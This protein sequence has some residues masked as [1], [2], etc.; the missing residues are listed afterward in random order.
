MRNVFLLLA[1]TFCGSVFAQTKTITFK[2]D[3]AMGK[4]A[5]IYTYFGCI[6]SGK[7]IPI[8]EMNHGNDPQLNAAAWTFSALGCGKGTLRAL[9]KFEE[10]STIPQNVVIVSAELKLYGATHYLSG[11]TVGNSLYPG[12][13]YS[14]QGSNAAYIQRVT[15]DW[16]DQTVTWNTQPTTTAENRIAIPQTTSQWNWG[17][18]DS[19][20]NLIKM[21][22]DMVTNPET[23][24]GFMIRLETESYYRSVQFASSNHPDP[25]L[26]P[27]LTVTYEYVVSG[28]TDRYAE[29][30]NPQAKK[31]DGS[32]TYKRI[33]EPI[34]G[35]M[36]STALNY[37]PIATIAGDGV[38]VYEV[39]NQK[40]YGCTDPKALNYNPEATDYDYSREECRCVYANDENTFKPIVIPEVPVDTLGAR[41]VEDCWFTAANIIS[42]KITKLTVSDIDESEN[43]HGKNKPPHLHAYAEWEIVK[44]A[45]GKIDTIRERVQY[46]LDGKNSSMDNQPTLFYMSVVCKNPLYLKS[47]IEVVEA[48]G[49][50]FSAFAYFDSF[51]GICQ[52]LVVSKNN[53]AVYPNPFTDK[54]TVLVKGAKTADIA[55]YSIEGS[56]LATYRNLNEVEIATSK[57]PA[58]V[59]VVKV[60]ADGETESVR[61]VKK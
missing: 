7:T 38:C 17:F 32:C 8:D 34:T 30:Y 26:H 31:N 57:L 14:D 28:C 53:V 24:F 51:T 15:S 22:Q 18:T 47:G 3:S 11:I 27:E 42:A 58:G 56:L 49:Y 25:A 43:N 54:L 61:V 33:D 19:S 20:E 50:T 9:L 60:I 46:C 13:P 55:L 16:D 4:D 2:P 40:L 6:S 12:S 35:C 45:G 36:D 41:A 52:P 39:A 44:E 21:I 59:Y 10:L 1:I 29:N 37:N 23:N 48:I 5:G